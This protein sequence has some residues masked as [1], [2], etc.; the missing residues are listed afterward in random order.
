MNIKEA[1]KLFQ[2]TLSSLACPYGFYQITGENISNIIPKIKLKPEQS[3]MIPLKFSRYIPYFD[4]CESFLIPK[5]LH[6]LHETDDKIIYVRLNENHE[7]DGFIEISKNEVYDGD[8][9]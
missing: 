6:F 4:D 1:I 7:P 8:H 3:L 5:N 2:D 9:F